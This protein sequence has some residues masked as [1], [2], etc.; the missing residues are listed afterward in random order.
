MSN[1]ID[2]FF[3]L[4]GPCPDKIPNCQK[5]REQYQA[6]LHQNQGTNCKN[7]D[8][9]KVQFKYMQIVWNIFMDSL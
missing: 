6:D 2:E 9:T 3:N 7:C 1:L 4:Q 5:L 8:I